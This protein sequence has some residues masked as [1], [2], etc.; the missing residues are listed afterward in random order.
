MASHL[1][2]QEKRFGNVWLPQLSGESRHGSALAAAASVCLFRSLRLYLCDLLWPAESSKARPV[3]AAFD[4]ERVDR[5]APPPAP[6]SSISWVRLARGAALRPATVAAA[7]TAAAGHGACRDGGRA[8][9][10]Q[11]WRR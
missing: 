7:A 2:R 11:L 5:T 6:A 8:R 4:C 9:G 3:P 1:G 10:R